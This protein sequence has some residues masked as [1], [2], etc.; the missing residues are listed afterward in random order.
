MPGDQSPKQSEDK[1]ERN[2]RVRFESD[3]ELQTSEQ[4]AQG[5]TVTEPEQEK[6]AVERKT[7]L[8]HVTVPTDSGHRR[9]QGKGARH[10][11]DEERDHLLQH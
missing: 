4:T 3:P 11:T 6:K 8:G 7:P 5:Q 10:I 9:K 2:H 1:N